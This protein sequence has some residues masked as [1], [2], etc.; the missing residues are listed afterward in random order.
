MTRLRS[1]RGCLLGALCLAAAPG[2]S[3]EVPSL[4]SAKPPAM[5]AGVEGPDFSRA[6]QAYGPQLETL[7]TDTEAL[8]LFTSKL[9]PSL[10]LSDAAGVLTAGPRGAPSLPGV[11]LQNLEASAIRLTAMLTQWRIAR[12]LQT[13]DEAG[14]MLGADLL[15]KHQQQLAWLEG[16]GSASVLGR[17]RPFV[18]ADG[19]AR[20]TPGA[21][22][23]HPT[24]EAYRAAVDR[25]Y[26]ETTGT[27]TAWLPLI[28]R[29]GAGVLRQRLIADPVGAPVPE[30]VRGQMAVR[31]ARQRLQPLIDARV[32][33]LAA[34]LE[35]EAVVSAYTEWMSL[36]GLRDRAREAAGLNRLCG[37]W[38]WTIHNHRNHG[39]QKTT[40]VFAAPGQE[41]PGA[42]RPKEIVVLGDVLYLRWELP[43]GV[44]QEDS[45]LFAGDGK[46]L[47][48]T[49]V[50]S[51]GSW[52]SI[53][54]KRLKACKGSEP[55][56]RPK[57]GR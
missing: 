12:M 4:P 26:P 38:L 44:L 7:S 6:V 33:A 11:S 56:P 22:V 28:E 50:N 54:G 21:D 55:A 36:Y 46:R 35:R 14:E 2:W 16:H 29:E 30:S 42:A 19:W 27:E 5:P 18:E 34:E 17:L 20:S 24:Y 52:G 31:Y 53:T 57:R 23:E 45:L 49:F 40:M 25:A 48:G 47:E 8:R 39:D 51:A 3:T 32:Q 1:F 10:G 43:G 37:S 41:Q 13:G 9:G 15:G